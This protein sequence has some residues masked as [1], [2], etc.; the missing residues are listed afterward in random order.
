MD[1]LADLLDLSRVR[2]ALVANVRGRAP[3]GLALPASPGASFHAVTSGT[4]WARVDGMAPVQLMPGDLLL[5]PNGSEHRLS[6]APDVSCRPFDRALKEESMT[7]AGDLELGENGAATAFVCA[8]YEYDLELAE[9]LISLLPPVLHVPADPVA[10]REITVLVELLAVEAGTRSPG[11]RAAAARLLDL[12]LIA[13]I[14]HWTRVQP[15]DGTPSWL[16][17]LRDPPVAR[18]LALLHA[19]PAES[20]TL[21]LLAREV[22]LSRATL[23]RRFTSAVGE[24]PLSYLARWRMHL[25]AQRLKDTSDAVAT[26]ARDV[27]YTSEYAFSRAFSRHRGQPPGRYRRAARAV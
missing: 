10:A 9:P 16:M 8:A 17:A 6:S 2:G 21:E 25:A 18:V 19:R 3:W 15:D 5:F 26:I 23:A 1:P 14:R 11:G 24:S 27:G 7:P 22:H 13:A 20:W 4:A 12:L